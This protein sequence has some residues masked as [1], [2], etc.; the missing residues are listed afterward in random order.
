MQLPHRLNIAAVKSMLLKESDNHLGTLSVFVKGKA[1]LCKT[2][3][4]VEISLK[5]HN[6]SPLMGTEKINLFQLWNSDK[7]RPL[8]LHLQLDKGFFPDESSSVMSHW[9]W[10]R[11][12]HTRPSTYLPNN[13][14]GYRQTLWMGLLYINII[15]SL[16]S[17]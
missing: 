12:I 13:K 7:I 2:L 6:T 3:I 8:N 1:I 17:G 4:H 14:L 5:H 10:V 9:C 16:S 15:T 11:G